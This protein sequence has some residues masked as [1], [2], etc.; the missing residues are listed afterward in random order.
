MIH[1]EICPVAGVRKS[2]DDKGNCTDDDVEEMLHQLAD[3]TIEY[4]R[5]IVGPHR[6][7]EKMSRR[8]GDHS[9]VT[10]I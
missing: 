9:W 8:D 1:P 5:K 3:T 2:F 6:M 4:V 7:L 10:T